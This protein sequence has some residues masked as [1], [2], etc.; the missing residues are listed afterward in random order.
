MKNEKTLIIIKPDSVQRSLVGEIIQRFERTG[1]KFVALKMLIPDRKRVLKHYYKDDA[2]FEKIGGRTVESKQKRNE[3][4]E[5]TA[6]EYGKD[7][8]KAVVDFLCSGPVI[9]LVMQG[10]HACGIIRKIIG[11]TEPLT[12]DVGTIRG[13][14]TVDSYSLADHDDR[15]VRNLVHASEFPEEAERE[16]KV[17]FTE[18]EIV[19][20]NLV[21]EKILYDVNLDG[22]KE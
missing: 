1:L 7:R 19:K 21:Q 22:I 6:I 13:D 18:D 4:V 5:K 8:Q 15:A 20:Y 3:P 9:V 17:W 12:S 2:W 14:F 10:S 11:G 16:M